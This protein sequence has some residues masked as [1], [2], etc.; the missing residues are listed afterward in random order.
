M[1]QH[2]IRVKW[3][4][5]WFLSHSRH[6]TRQWTVSLTQIFTIFRYPSLNGFVEIRSDPAI[7]QSAHSFL[8]LTALS[9]IERHWLSNSF[10]ARS[11]PFPIPLPSPSP[12]LCR[13][14]PHIS[15]WT[16]NSLRGRRKPLK[17]L[18]KSIFFLFSIYRT[19]DFLTFLVKPLRSRILL[20]VLQILLTLPFVPSFFVATVDIRTS[21]LSLFLDFL[22][23]LLQSLSTS[24][25]HSTV[26]PK[27]SV[28][29]ALV[30][31]PQKPIEDL[32]FKI[33]NFSDD[34]LYDMGVDQ[35]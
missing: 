7:F 1:Q 33:G 5:Q 34:I 17:F 4:R 22:L 14:L 28:N 10:S 20:F 35:I 2:F 30:T 27:T 16:R 3:H 12:I 15:D 23:R 29:P 21:A 31:T 18:F 9:L 8:I 13:L 11:W 24:A 25:S 19:L 6:H 26:L 32:S